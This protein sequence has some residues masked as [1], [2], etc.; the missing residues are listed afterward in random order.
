MCPDP[1]P[2]PPD[3]PNGRS[4]RALALGL[5]FIFGCSWA[6][7]PPE[8]S[9]M[10]KVLGI[11][12][13]FFK[14]D[15]PAQ[16]ARWYEDHLGISL[17]PS[18][19]EQEPWQQQA[20]PTVFAPFARSTSY[21]GRAEQTWMINFRVADLPAM[22]EQLTAAGIVVSAIETF[23][24]GLFTRLEDPEGNP[25]QLWEPRSSSR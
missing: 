5:I 22:V 17:V 2:A 3:R 15:D 11:G 4:L 9:D 20:G 23:P 24:N 18:T 7:E 6:A 16:L 21:F 1:A 14:S 25:I 8:E 10:Q 12:G 19:Y 13:L